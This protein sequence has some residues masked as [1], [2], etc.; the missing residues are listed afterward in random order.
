MRGSLVVTHVVQ[1]NFKTLLELLL[2]NRVHLV[3]FRIRMPR[4]VVRVVLRDGILLVALV[5][6]T[7]VQQVNIS[8]QQLIRIAQIAQAV[9]TKI[10]LLRQVANRVQVANTKIPQ[11]KLNA[12]VVKMVNSKTLLELPLVKVV[13]LA[14]SLPMIS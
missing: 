1:V 9:N 3:N 12:S 6:V 8:L 2:A 4:L 13:L 14:N 11:V 5:I 10:N 7:N